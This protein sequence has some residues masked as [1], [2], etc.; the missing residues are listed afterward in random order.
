MPPG[1]KSPE[2]DVP[3]RELFKKSKII[4][5]GSV[6]KKLELREV[7]DFSKKSENPGFSYL[8]SG[9]LIPKLCLRS[10]LTQKAVKLEKVFY[11]KLF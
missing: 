1:I 5:I 10:E 6:E 2:M 9:V 4:E 7:G 3:D 8:K 11:I